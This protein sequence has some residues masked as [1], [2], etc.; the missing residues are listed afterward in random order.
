MPRSHECPATKA[1]R[2]M[3]KLWQCYLHDYD[4]RKPWSPSNV[5][6]YYKE[7]MI[8]MRKVNNA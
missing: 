7:K 3:N 5:A 8:A 4:E 6:A 1:T 2:T